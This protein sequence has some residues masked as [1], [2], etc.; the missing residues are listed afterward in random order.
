MFKVDKE[1]GGFKLSH[2]KDSTRTTIDIR[3]SSDII[4]GYTATSTGRVNFKLGMTNKY[5]SDMFIALI[6]LPDLEVSKRSTKAILTYFTTAITSYLLSLSTSDSSVQVYSIRYSVKFTRLINGAK[7]LQEYFFSSV[8]KGLFIPR[9][10]LH[11]AY[12]LGRQDISLFKNHCFHSSISNISLN[13]EFLGSCP[14]IDTDSKIHMHQYAR[15]RYNLSAK[16]YVSGSD[17][18][19]VQK[20]VRGIKISFIRFLQEMYIR[21][22][23]HDNDDVYKFVSKGK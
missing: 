3:D 7:A 20:E 22:S 17:I 13:S 5:V 6:M 10:S 11:Y 15:H 18:P 14:M 16:A 2:E 9:T 8:E 12:A 21:L 4:T 23:T 19:Y 1:D